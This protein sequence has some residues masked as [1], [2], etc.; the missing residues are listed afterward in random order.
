MA[1]AV[2][3]IVDS[4]LRPTSPRINSIGRPGN[5][6]VSLSFDATRNLDYTLQSRASLSAGVWAALQEFGS[7]P[8]DRSLS[9]TNTISGSSRFY[10]LWARP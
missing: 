1:N 5:N 3:W 6:L 7:S 9:V 2:S 8:V 10:R 4:T